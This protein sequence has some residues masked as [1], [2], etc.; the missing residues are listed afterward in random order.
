MSFPYSPIFATLLPLRLE[1]PACGRLLLLGPTLPHA[2]WF[3]P[4][5]ARLTCMPPC[6]KTYYLGMLIWDAEGRRGGGMPKP[7]V[8]VV[9]TRRQLAEL[10]QYVGGFWPEE[11]REKRGPVEGTS[12]PV[13]RYLGEGEVCVCAP[14]LWRAD[15]PVHGGAQI[16][17]RRGEREPEGG[18][19]EGGV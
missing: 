9:P 11:R 7:P 17:L 2:K 13:N 15:C 18:G 16:G 1:C 6:G 12:G 3:D 19:E 4:L 8:D 5:R 10:R 14:E